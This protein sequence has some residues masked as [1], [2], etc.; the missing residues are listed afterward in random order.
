[1]LFNSVWDYF[2]SKSQSDA[3]KQA[4]FEYAIATENGVSDYELRLELALMRGIGQTCQMHSAKLI[5]I[6]IPQMTAPYK[7]GSSLP[8]SLRNGIREIGADMIMSEDVLT[9]FA[10]A[11]EL[12]VPGGHHHISEL[13]HTLLGIALGQHILAAYK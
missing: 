6:D 9:D 4:G 7:F 8:D 1:V 5:V 2:K 11:T 13:T 3:V 10:G 12:H